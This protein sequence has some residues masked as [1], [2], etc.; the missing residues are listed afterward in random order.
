LYRIKLP[1]TA[2]HENVGTGV[3][4]T[5]LG[6]KGFGIGG[7]VTVK[8]MGLLKSPGPAALRPRICHVYEPA[9]RTFGGVAEQV[10]PAH[11]LGGYQTSK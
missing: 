3:V 8:A 1:P 5:P 11:M 2:L 10:A 9:L 6:D 7:P 4:R